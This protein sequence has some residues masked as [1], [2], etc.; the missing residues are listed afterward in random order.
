MRKKLLVVGIALILIVGGYVALQINKGKSNSSDTTAST[1]ASKSSSAS[2]TKSAHEFDKTAHS[3]TDASSPWV[4]VNKKHPLSPLNYAPVDLMLV[5]NGQYMRSEAAQALNTMFAAASSAGISLVADSAYR[6]YDTQ[7]RVYNSEVKAYGQA[8]A[9]S[10]SARPGYSEH[11]TGWAIDIGTTG[12][13][14]A[15]CFGG[16][17]AGKWAAAHAYLYGFVLRYP[18][19]K[20]TITGYRNESWHFRYV[21]V[22]LATEMHAKNVETLEEFFDVSGGDYK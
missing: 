13:H 15:D 7:V 21:G 12:C 1:A 17:P 3:L 16:T 8:K 9:D 22:K 4:I 5:G 19:E 20:A 11:Q 18:E 6:S 2:G 14:V 10:E